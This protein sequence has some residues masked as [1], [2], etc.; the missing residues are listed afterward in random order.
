MMPAS[1]LNESLSDSVDMPSRPAWSVEAVL[2]LFALPLN[3]LLYRAQ[4]VHRAHFDPNA[5][6]VSTLLSIKTGGCPE[7]C[8]YCP[9]AARYHTDIEGNDLM[10]VSQVKA[11]AL[12]AKSN[13][14]S[15]VCMGAAWRNVKDGEEFDQ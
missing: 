14:S 11:Q 15:R 13:G 4:T 12:R 6:Q 3:D 2:A 9:Q 1:S 8:G 5:V 10:T 7:D